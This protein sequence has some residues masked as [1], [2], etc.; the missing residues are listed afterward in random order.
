MTYMTPAESATAY[1]DA[2]RNGVP[3]SNDDDCRD[4]YRRIEETGGELMADEKF[5][6][7]CLRFL[8]VRATRDDQRALDEFRLLFPAMA[9]DWVEAF[10]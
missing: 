8:L 4:A 6:A 2:W 7:A 10:E 5:R 1:F 3:P 9:K